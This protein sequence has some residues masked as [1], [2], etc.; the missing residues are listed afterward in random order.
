M[1][2]AQRESRSAAFR[3]Q[4]GPTNSVAWPVPL[5]R[6]GSADFQSAVSQVCN[7]RAVGPS[8]RTCEDGPAR[9]SEGAQIENLRYSRLQTCATLNAFV[10]SVSPCP[11]S[12]V[13]FNQPA[14][15]SAF[16]LTDLLVSVAGISVLLALVM[17]GST[18]IGQKSRLAQCTANL[19]AIDRG[20]L[21]FCNDNSQTLPG[22]N[23]DSSGSLWWFYKEQ[24]KHYVGLSGPSSA[25]DAVFACAD[26][27]GYS[28][29]KPFHLSQRFDYSSYVYNGV[30][31]PGLPNIAG[32]QLA[33]VK[34]PARTLLVMEWTAHAPLSWHRSKTGKSNMPFYCDAQSVVGFVDGH[35]SFSKI[36]YDGY[37]AAYT[38]DPPPSYDYQY[39]GN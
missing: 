26:D 29:P 3:L 9:Y 13:N 19:Q 32:W 39:S 30:T 17:I 18:T 33:S 16:T 38:Q 6:I 2:C 11:S 1:S 37:N 10:H 21:S 24:V 36:Y 35:V 4:N 27:R 22:I 28:D 8:T 31:L 20:V 23:A 25:T 5:Y 14:C 7:L 15:D 34:H 12:T